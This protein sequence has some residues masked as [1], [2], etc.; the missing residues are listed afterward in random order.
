MAD[1]IFCII[2]SDFFE[3]RSKEVRVESAAAGKKLGWTHQSSKE[4]TSAHSSL[5]SLKNCS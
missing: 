4:D 2:S 1:L 5:I 3:F